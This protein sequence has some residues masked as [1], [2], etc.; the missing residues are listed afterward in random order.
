MA[1]KRQQEFEQKNIQNRLLK[2][3]IEQG[4]MN[5]RIQYMSKVKE[6]AEKTKQHIKVTH[7]IELQS[8]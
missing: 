1:R 5:T 8:S 7:V 3:R 4:T 6:D 2:E